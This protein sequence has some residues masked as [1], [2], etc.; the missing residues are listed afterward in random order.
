MAILS[1]ATAAASTASSYAFL[2]ATSYVLGSGQD[3][4][5]SKENVPPLVPLSSTRSSGPSSN[6]ESNPHAS[7]PAS[8]AKKL[9]RHNSS[10][11]R[12]PSYNPAKIAS[13][14]PSSSSRPSTPRASAAAA[15]KA[16]KASQR[17]EGEEL[18]DSINQTEELYAILGVGKRA[19]QEEI[20]RGFLSRSRICHPDKL[21]DYPPSTTAFQRLSYAYETLSKPSSRRIYDLGGLKSFDTAGMPSSSSAGGANADET[22]NGVLRGIINEF[23][24]GDFEMVRVFVTALNDGSP[25]LNLGEDAIDNLESAF[26]KA[27]EILLAGHKYALLVKFS[28]IRMYEIQIN[29]R[30][31]G[32]FDLYARLRLTIELMRC[33]VEVPLILDKAMREDV[34]PA[35]T[36]PDPT[37]P[38]STSWAESDDR[39]AGGQDYD[40]TTAHGQLERRGILGARTKGMLVLTCRVLEK[41]ERWTGGTTSTSST[42]STYSWEDDT[43]PNPPS[44]SKTEQSNS[45]SGDQGR[46]ESGTQ[47]SP[48][49]ESGAAASRNTP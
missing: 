34:S 19:K 25:G 21:P 39:Q 4:S 28:L 26:G 6:H 45:D 40:S 36:S 49:T 13:S 43:S 42:R 7:C 37:E 33:M 27:R 38:A 48:T 30:R 22:L 10:A 31:L 24:N 1:Y 5:A 17:G 46:G 15:V 11:R 14:S 8:P 29:L 12:L 32:Y 44:T 3:R 16:K 35:H 2:T 23:L 18:V 41:A 20:R 47:S 9:T